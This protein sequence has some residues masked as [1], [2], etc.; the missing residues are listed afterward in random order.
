M[1]CNDAPWSNLW[2]SSHFNSS[3]LWSCRCDI[4]P[5]GFN[6]NFTNLSIWCLPFLLI[7]SFISS[8]TPPFS[9]FFGYDTLVVTGQNFRS[10]ACYSLNLTCCI[11]FKF[12]IKKESHHSFGWR[13]F[14]WEDDVMWMSNFAKNE[15]II[16]MRDDLIGTGMVWQ[17]NVCIVWHSF[18]GFAYVKVS[19][20]CNFSITTVPLHPQRIPSLSHYLEEIEQ[21]KIIV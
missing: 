10:K 8:S 19:V 21:S 14:V 18:C 12:N 17:C 6:Y 7:Y 20:T 15:S 11:K 13:I 1:S 4:S 16:Y 3:C 2:F 5:A 9:S